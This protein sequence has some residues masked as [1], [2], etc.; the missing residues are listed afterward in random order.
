MTEKGTRG[1]KGDDRPVFSTHGEGRRRQEE[2]RAIG[3]EGR[4]RRNKTG[5]KEIAISF[6]NEEL[7]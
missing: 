3:E 7:Q 2:D 1:W 5:Y 4:G 6:N